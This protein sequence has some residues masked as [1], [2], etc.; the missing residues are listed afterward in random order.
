MWTH[1]SKA[2]FRKLWFYW[3]MTE[4]Y[5]SWVPFPLKHECHQPSSTHHFFTR[6]RLSVVSNTIQTAISLGYTHKCVWC[7]NATF[8]SLDVSSPLRTTTPPGSTIQSFFYCLLLITCVLHIFI[9]LYVIKQRL[10]KSIQ[11]TITQSAQYMLTQLSRMKTKPWFWKM[12][13]K[14]RKPIFHF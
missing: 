12:S 7:T 6:E 5:N 13:L 4:G 9:K 11:L 8:C 14:R 2:A 10:V 3:P 1:V